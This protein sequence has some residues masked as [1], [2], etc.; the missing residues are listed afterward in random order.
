M[1]RLFLEF[2]NPATAALVCKQLSRRLGDALVELRLT[3]VKKIF[4]E[5]H[6]SITGAQYRYDVCC[7]VMSPHEGVH[8]LGVSV[9]V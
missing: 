9:C 4:E 1:V 7:F 2:H 3:N 8:A 6:G 5:K